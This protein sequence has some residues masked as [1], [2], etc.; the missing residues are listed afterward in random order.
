MATGHG[1]GGPSGSAS[2]H[3]CAGFRQ[4][5][6]SLSKEGLISGCPS[7]TNESSARQ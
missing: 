7:L 1:G 4:R 6:P 2:N 3:P 5:R